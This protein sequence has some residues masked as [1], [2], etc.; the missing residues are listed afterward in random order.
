[1]GFVNN[2]KAK[3]FNGGKE[4]RT[5]TDDNLGMFRNEEFLPDL[6]SSR[7]GL[8]GVDEGYLSAESIF[9]NLDK[10]AGEGDFW[11]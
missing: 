3:V 7:F 9:K 10:L 11:N 1:M 4:G 5:R 2:D 6:M 8:V